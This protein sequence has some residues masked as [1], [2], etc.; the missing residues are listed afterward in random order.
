MRN[1]YQMKTGEGLRS[2]T[3]VVEILVPWETELVMQFC[4]ETSQHPI[5]SASLAAM[6]DPEE[7]QIGIGPS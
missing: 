3:V 1:S 6:L 5:H 4:A 7:E 2:E